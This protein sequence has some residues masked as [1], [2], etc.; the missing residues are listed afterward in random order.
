MSDTDTTTAPDSV[1]MTAPVSSDIAEKFKAIAKG[2]NIPIR[3]LGGMLYERFVAD[4]AAGKVAVAPVQ[5]VTDPAARET[6]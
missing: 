6:A 2:N 3:V 5:L 4:H 1:L